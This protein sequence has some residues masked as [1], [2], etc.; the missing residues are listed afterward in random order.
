M[1]RTESAEGMDRR[2][3]RRRWSALS[4]FITGR[5][6][7]LFTHRIRRIRRAIVGAVRNGQNERKLSHEGQTVDRIELFFTARRLTFPFNESQVRVGLDGGRERG[8]RMGRQTRPMHSLYHFGWTGIVV[9]APYPSDQRQTRAELS[10]VAATRLP[11]W[12]FCTSSL[13]R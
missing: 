9:R 10:V 1:E 6:A 12:L 11:G 5:P 8:C 2:R 7:V 4:S 3:F 13:D